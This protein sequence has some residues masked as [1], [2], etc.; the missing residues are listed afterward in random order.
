[1]TFIIFMMWAFCSVL[2]FSLLQKKLLQCILFKYFSFFKYLEEE[3]RKSWNITCV[4]TIHGV[5]VSI[6][7]LILFLI[8]PEF[9]TK[10]NLHYHDGL[11]GSCLYLLSSF[12][13]GYFIFDLVSNVMT[14]L[15]KQWIYLLHHI[16]CIISIVLVLYYKRYSLGILIC[17]L[18]EGS[19]FFI[20]NI[21]FF[22]LMFKNS[23][24]P[25]YKHSTSKASTTL[26]DTRNFIFKGISNFER[27]F[28]NK[29]TKKAIKLFNGICILVS[30]IVWRLGFGIYFYWKIIYINRVEFF[31]DFPIWMWWIVLDVSLQH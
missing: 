12:S 3:E 10:Y 29:M 6:G 7:F 30:W 28:K 21:T 5:V 22:K 2:F 1:M 16:P 24:S 9:N 23:E 11:T 18:M 17:E 15:K 8:T 25:Y 26:W 14:D 27:N 19:T 31:E 4:S 13:L 20:N